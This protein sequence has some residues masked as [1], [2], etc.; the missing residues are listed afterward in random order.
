MGQ[1]DKPN[2][3]FSFVRFEVRT[4]HLDLGKG[5]CV[6]ILKINKFGENHSLLS[7]ESSLLGGAGFCCPPKPLHARQSRYPLQFTSQFTPLS[8]LSKMIEPNTLWIWTL[9]SPFLLQR[10]QGTLILQLLTHIASYHLLVS[11]QF[12]F[13]NCAYTSISLYP[14]WDAFLCD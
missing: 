14:K 1:E 3:Q 11:I 10:Q 7:T 8:Q 13:L 6:T 5:S 2:D 4:H 12:Q 9:S